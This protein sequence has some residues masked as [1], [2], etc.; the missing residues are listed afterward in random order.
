[1]AASDFG[2]NNFAAIADV[3]R[4]R[5]L[6]AYD[7]A[8]KAATAAV[9]DVGAETQSRVKANLGGA[10]FSSRWQASIKARF[11]PRSVNQPSI[12]AKAHIYSTINF[13]SVFEN[14]TRINGKPLLWL[15]VK[16]IPQKV[17][18]Q[19]MTPTLFK[20][21]YGPLRSAKR[22]PIPIL[23]GQIG[24]AASGAPLRKTNANF[25]KGASGGQAAWVPCFVGVSAVQLRKRLNYGDIFN[26]ARQELPERFAQYLEQYSR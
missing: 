23:L 17:G 15:P 4:Q 9:R 2:S 19:P 13:L 8:A 24:T 11:T 25:R 1:M 21:I 10:G 7:P 14:G 12:N 20:Q 26:H 3:F 16:D 18:G 22:S 5:T 6:G